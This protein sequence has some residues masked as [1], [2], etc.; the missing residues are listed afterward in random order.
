M[1]KKVLILL[2]TYNGEKYLSEQVESLENQDNADVD[3][4]IRDDG[5]SDSTIKV[6]EQLQSAYTNIR[7]IKGENLGF[8]KSFWDLIKNAEGYDYYG[9]CDQDDIWLNDK[10]ARAVSRLE[11]E[12]G[13]L[14]L[15]YTGDV[16]C[17]DSNGDKISDSPFKGK[18]LNNYE[19]FQRSIL[20]GC[21]YFFNDNTLQLIKK[22]DGS[23]YAHDWAVYAI[24]KTFGKVVYDSEP[25]MKYRIHSNNTI[26]ADGKFKTIKNKIKLF[27]KKSPCV[28]MN[29][30][31]DFYDCYGDSILDKELKEAVYN[32]GHYQESFSIKRK[33]LNNKNFHGFSFKLY[34]VLNRV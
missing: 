29:F 12:D 16:Y 21:T 9:F 18:V 32:L 31:R 26:G 34:V 30:A 20:P 13:S 24:V 15:L 14:P 10:V 7:F 28:R 17:V 6:I 23:M 5:S 19:T 3:I 8:A 4:L 11:K 1:S 25:G 27:F 22:Y 2:S 33:L